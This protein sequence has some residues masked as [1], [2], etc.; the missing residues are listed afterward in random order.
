MF[1]RFARAPPKTRQVRKFLQRN[2]VRD[3]EP[4]LEVGRRLCR[5][6]LEVFDAG[7]GVI[8][9]VHAD[10]LENFRIFGEAVFLEARFGEFPAP[11]VSGAVV[12]LAAPAGIFPRGRADEDAALRELRKPVADAF[13]VELDAGLLVRFDA[14]TIGEAKA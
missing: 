7:K 1:I 9:S 4:E 13:A 12:E 10:G 3:L 6:A 8:G 5:E 14:S 11:F 2:L